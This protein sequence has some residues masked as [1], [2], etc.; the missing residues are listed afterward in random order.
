MQ[1]LTPSQARTQLELQAQ[2][3]KMVVHINQKYDLI[4]ISNTEGYGDVHLV[5]GQ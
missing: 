1:D 4:F 5:E 2:G 3:R